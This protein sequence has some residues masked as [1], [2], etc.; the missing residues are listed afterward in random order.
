VTPG[1]LE[2][3]QI[4]VSWSVTLPGVSAIIVADERRL[5]GDPLARA[6]PPP[7]RD[8]AIFGLWLL[9]VHP[10]CV[11][12]HFVKTRWSLAGA[13]LGMLW[14]GALVGADVGAQW[15]AEAAIDWLGL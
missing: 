13:G 5:V 10:L 7:S 12:V 1:N 9:G 6:W 15:G 2:L 4:L 3:V 14:L 8:A 11:L